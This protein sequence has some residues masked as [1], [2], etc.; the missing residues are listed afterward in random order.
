MKYNFDE[1]INRRDTGS[2][3]WDFGELLVEMGYAEKFDEN[4]L[5]LFTADMD[6]PVPPAITEAMHNVANNRI[7]GYSMHTP[8]YFDAV[9]TWFKKRHNW[10]IKPEEIIYSPGTVYALGVA[11]RAYTN[12]GDG[13]IIQRPVYTPFTHTIEGNGRV[14]ANNQMIVDDNGFYV[15]D[16]E[17]FKRVASKP[18][19]KLFILCN[20]HNPSGRIFSDSDLK[21]MAQICM[22][23]NVIIVADE[24]HGDLI[25][26]DSKFKPIA[27]LA[28]SDEHIITCTAINK[29][30]NVAGLHATNVVIPNKEL[31]DKF[32][33]E[34]GMLLPTPFTTAAVIAGYNEGEEWLE[35]LK[36]YFD[37][38]IDW[39]LNFVKEKLP[40]VKCVR[41]EGTYVFWMDFRDYGLTAEEI[42][43]KIYVDANVILE[44]GTLF[45]P[46]QGE[47]FERICL[48]SPRPMI[49]E[50]FERIAKEFEGL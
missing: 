18:E 16:L 33:A 49:K 31:R 12:R 21:A 36:A 6:I 4:T 5:P 48:S 42:R 38:T 23:N 27:T 40:K 37:D 9:I 20:P 3:K 34:I 13:V 28:T 39:V 11:I 17:D 25:R 7:Y 43:Q 29:T 47:G 41:P 44:S 35:A 8:S 24:I 2:I 45:D 30:F 22:E 10:T 19:N 15:I 32:E 14:V 1:I 50:A 26:C 46:D